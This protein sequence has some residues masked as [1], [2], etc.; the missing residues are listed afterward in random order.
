MWYC[1]LSLSSLYAAVRKE[2]IYGKV[3]IKDFTHPHTR[4]TGCRSENLRWLSR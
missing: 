2:Q 1:V 4:V 3:P